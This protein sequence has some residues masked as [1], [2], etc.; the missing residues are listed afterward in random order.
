MKV[1]ITTLGCKTNQFESAAMA[2]KLGKEGFEMVSFEETADIYVINT[3]TVTART[4]AESRRLIRRAMRRN[5]A[6]RIVVTGCYA[7]VAPTELE[8]MDGVNLIV[9]NAEKKDIAR[10]LWELGEERKTVVSDISREHRAEVLPL[11]SFA[12]HTRAFLQVQNGCDA[13]CSYCIVPHARGRSRS[14]PPED[15]LEGYAIFAGKGFREIVLTGIHLSGYGRDLTPPSSLLQLLQSIGERRLTPRLRLGSLEPME[16][17]DELIDFIAASPDICPHLH[18]PLQSGDDEVLRRMNRHYSSEYFHDLLMRITRRIPDICIGVDII[19]GFPGETEQE[20]AQ[21]L[22]FAESLPLAY[23]HVFPF[24][25][26]PGTPAAT[27]PR[28]VRPAVI[29]E[30]ARQL[31]LVSDRKK[32]QYA[33]SFIGKEVRV[34]VQSSGGDGLLTGL[35][36]H[37]LPVSFAGPESLHNQEVPVTVVSPTETSLF[38]TLVP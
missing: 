25:S 16:I 30:R 14:V 18:I 22:A 24:S 37:Y 23:M 36:R 31:R 4:D 27:M 32:A 38:G 29:S 34:L 33:R 2:E 6:A 13:F 10:L 5:A 26:R 19:A 12:E 15:V 28:A 7:Q 3:C 9:G 8:K 11:E 21:T 17:G 35:S 1:A 20:F